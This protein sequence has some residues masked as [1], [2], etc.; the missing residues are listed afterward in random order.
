MTFRKATPTLESRRILTFRCVDSGSRIPSGF[1]GNCQEPSRPLRRIADFA[2]K[3]L[4]WSRD[5]TAVSFESRP[6]DQT[7][8]VGEGCDPD[9]FNP[10]RCLWQLSLPLVFKLHRRTLRGRFSD[11]EECT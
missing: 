8:G 11:I 1:R 7:T 3:P 10:T 2:S 4:I 9:Y 6:T 5:T